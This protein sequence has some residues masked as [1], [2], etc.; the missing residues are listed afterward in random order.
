MEWW[1]LL[2]VVVGAILFLLGLGIPVAFAFVLI[3]LVGVLVLQGGG[4]A[5][6]SVILSM[7]SSV[8]VFTLLPVPLFILMGEVL[9]HS[10]VA[11]KAIDVID[12]LLGRVPARLSIL[13]VL[14]GTVFSSLSGSTMAN[15]AMLGTILL[16]DMER[17][18]YKRAMSIGPILAS[19]G[20][21][22]MIP[23]SALAVIL[24]AI[25]QLS[26]GR[27]IIGAI[28]PGLM[29][30]A[31]FLAYILIRCKLQPHLTPGYEVERA[32]AREIAWSLVVDLAPLAVI[33]FLVTGVI[34]I[35][36]ATPTEAAALG[37][38]G[39]FIIAA[40]YR[41]L[42]WEVIQKSFSG[43]VH[44][45]VMTLT[46]VIGAQGFSQLLAFSGAT[47]GLLESV[48][49]LPF[50]PA[51]LII[52]MQIIVL[53]LGAF[54]EQVSIMLITLPIFIPLVV[55]LGFDPIW[56]AVLLLINLEMALTTPPFGLLLFVMKGVA[57]PG[58]TMRE[59]YSAG[60][61]FLAC[62]AVAMAIVF[63]YPET[64]TWLQDL[65]FTRR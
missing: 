38:F 60:L 33:V 2:V 39:S 52:L 4:R 31:L 56:F 24:A 21:A 61:P 25:A 9:W 16:P 8:S 35:G 26:V 19:G 27:I 45:S 23:P 11:F 20:L 13:T 63:V 10:R 42:T 46:I 3:N 6:H 29:M 17:R 50:S 41:M 7:Y 47:R 48:T 22:M 43:T 30:A 54:M 53:F 51:V 34:V 37:C 14:S 49:S 18:G 28:I 1:L 12:K 59:I 58:T 40:A 57:P 55:A 5:F 64:V 62:N 36:V 65:V 44:I 15:T 32:P